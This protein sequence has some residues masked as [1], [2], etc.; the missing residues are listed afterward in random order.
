MLG[1]D[2]RR[3]GG[4]EL[5]SSR[6]VQRQGIG[7]C[8]AGL[9][10]GGGAVQHQLVGQ[11]KEP[12]LGGQ[13]VIG[14]ENMAFRIAELVAGEVQAQRAL[15]D[16]GEILTVH[17]A[18][19][20][21]QGVAEHQG[22][23]VRRQ[24]QVGGQYLPAAQGGPGPQQ[25]QGIRGQHGILRLRT[26]GDG[27]GHRLR[28]LGRRDLGGEIH[29]SGEDGGVLRP[30]SEPEGPGAAIGHGQ[31]GGELVDAGEVAHLRFQQR[32][33]GVRVGGGQRRRIQGVRIRLFAV[34]MGL[35]E[36]SGQV[37]EG[38]AAA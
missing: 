10:A 14:G 30:G 32:Q 8:A 36:Q 27:G 15:A 17:G 11:L 3:D 2:I 33:Q 21:L 24:R 16:G 38:H 23:A 6:L 18:A 12:G 4:G 7:I 26:A 1:L 34:H 37:G 25:A 35:A 5:R 20:I 13:S 31:H 9:G 29:H 19:V 22:A 28:H